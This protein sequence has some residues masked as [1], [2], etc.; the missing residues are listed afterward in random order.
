MLRYEEALALLT[1]AAK[2]AG[3][4][5]TEIVELGEAS[6][7]VAAE[8]KGVTSELFGNWKSPSPFTRLIGKA[9]PVTTIN[10][11]VET[12]DK[13]N[14]FFVAAYTME[15]R[16]DNPDY[17]A[18]VLGN[19]MLGGGFLNSR[20][21]VRIRQKDGLSYGVGSNF[22]ASS[23][24]PVGTFLAFAIYAPENVDKL[25]KAFNEE[26]NRVIAEGF[27]SDEISAAKS[28]WSQ[29]RT[30]G[31][32]QDGGLSN[33]LNNYLFVNRNLSWDES[34]EK[35]VL[36]LTPDQINGAMKKYLTPAKIN[37]IKAGD[38]AKAK[39]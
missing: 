8:I 18:M 33:T 22:N 27:T 34:F 11:S 31:R 26:I 3:A 15:M 2:A 30:V 23:L 38:F 10:Q 6:G 36:S 39:K 32:A 12:P 7:R 9:V 19:Y 14:A 16:D 28:G 25:E 35:Q 4:P 21:A 13:A 1:A 37:I 24:D 20:L 17:P 29:S 5:P